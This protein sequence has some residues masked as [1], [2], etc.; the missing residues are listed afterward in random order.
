MDKS[1]QSVWIH[2]EKA[3]TARKIGMGLQTQTARFPA[4]ALLL[5]HVISRTSQILLSLVTRQPATLV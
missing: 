2:M 3:F 4:M 5:L 1:Q